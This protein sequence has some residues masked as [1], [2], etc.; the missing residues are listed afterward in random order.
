MISSG[1]YSATASIVAVYGSGSPTSPTASMPARA[2]RAREVDAHLRGIEDGVVVDDVAVAR[3][4]AR[5]ADDDADVAVP[6]FSLDRGDQ[7]A[8][9]SVSLA[10]TRIVLMAGSPR[11]AGG[12][13]R[14]PAA[15]HLGALEHAMDRAGDA[16]LVRAADDGRD[17][18]EVEDRRRRGD[19]PLERER[20]PRVRGRP[21]A[22]APRRDHVVEED[23]RLRPSTNDAIEITRFQP[24]NWSA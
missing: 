6:A 21:R 14:G 5:H 3:T 9:P 22:A 2:A 24:A 8:P 12:G 18:V 7:L 23:Q 4:V 13:S 20:P 10:T 17:R 1:A 11:P 16:V 15:R 19:L